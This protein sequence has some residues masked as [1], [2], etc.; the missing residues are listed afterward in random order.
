M[1]AS[2]DQLDELATQLYYSST[3]DSCG[4]RP[5][6]AEGQ[7]LSVPQGYYRCHR[8][9]TG[10]TGVLPVP[11]GYYR[12]LLELAVICTQLDDR[13]RGLRLELHAS[14]QHLLCSSASARCGAAKHPRRA[15]RAA[16]TPLDPHTSRLKPHAPRPTPQAP[17]PTPHAARRTPHAARRTPHASHASRLTPHACSAAR[18][19]WRS[20]AC[21]HAAITALYVG[22]VGRT[23]A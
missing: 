23:P 10:A 1:H 11:Q 5:C 9:T 13:D 18:V 3:A 20:A 17:R 7:V 8:G 15:W 4:G 19:A 12:C 6:A 16:L 14:C 21:T 2:G 22:P